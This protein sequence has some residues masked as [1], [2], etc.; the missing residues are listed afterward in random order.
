M[1]V[2]GWERAAELMR[3]LERRCLATQLADAAQAVKLAMS[4]H[5]S[6]VDL[7]TTRALVRNSLL[8]RG[9]GP[10]IAQR[11]L[12]YFQKFPSTGFPITFQCYSLSY[13]NH[14]G[15]VIRRAA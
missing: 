10:R 6:K 11:S 5:R 12:Q 4:A 9:A 1:R 3:E 7:A 8:V 15:N 13:L 2:A 14:P